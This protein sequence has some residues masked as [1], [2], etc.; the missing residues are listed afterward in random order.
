[1]EFENE[2]NNENV[3]KQGVNREGMLPEGRQDRYQGYKPGRTP[4]PRIQ[5]NRTY[6]NDRGGYRRNN[7]DEGGFR[8]E[9]FGMGLQQPANLHSQYRPRR[10][11]NEDFA[12]GRGGYQARSQYRPRYNDAENERL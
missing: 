2:K 11:G 10:N 9:G 12:A 7:N 8:P 3:E 6:N 1:M 4:R 5:T